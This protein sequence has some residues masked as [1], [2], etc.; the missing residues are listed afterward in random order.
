MIVGGG[1]M[2]GLWPV[3]LELAGGKDAEI[4]VIPTANETVTAEDRVV[5]ALLALGAK[6]VVQLHTRDRVVADTEEFVA[7]LRAAR[8]VWLSGGRQWRLADAYLNTRTLREMVVL[9]ERGGV[10]GGSSA[11]ATIQGSYMVRGAPEGNQIMMAPDTRKASASCVRRR[12]I[13]T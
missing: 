12:L 7:P 5:G 6:R 2:A 10:V 8:G 4:V 3:F 1:S 13:S 9:L 11:G